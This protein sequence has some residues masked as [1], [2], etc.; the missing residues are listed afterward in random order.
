MRWSGEIKLYTEAVCRITPCFLLSIFFPTACAIKN[1]PS[2][3]TDITSSHVS[4]EYSQKSVNKAR[5]FFVFVAALF[6]RM[7]ICEKCL[8]IF[9]TAHVAD[10]G[11]DTS[12]GN[13]RKLFL[14][15]SFSNSADN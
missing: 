8:Q 12:Q 1:I 4:S 9:S 14:S 7:S 13:K 11:L 5:T 6:K 2:K 10:L 3:L 15:Y